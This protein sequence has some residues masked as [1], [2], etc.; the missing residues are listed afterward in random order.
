MRPEKNLIVEQIQQHVGSVPFVILIDYTGMKVQEFAEL[1]GRLEAAQCTCHVVKN[2]L[3]KRALGAAGLP[4]LAEHLQG[5]TAVVLGQ[6]DISAAAKALKNFSAEFSKPTIKVGILDR[7]VVDQGQLK[8]LADLPSREVLLAQIA[9]LLQAPAANLA[10][11]VN[12]PASRIAQA[13]KFRSGQ[14]A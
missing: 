5:Q 3:L 2:T 13:L 1:R 9:G 6:G 12:A 14:S 11:L 7:S 4:E 10:R 8:Q